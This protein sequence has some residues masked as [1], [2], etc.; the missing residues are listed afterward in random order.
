MFLFHLFFIYFLSTIGCL[1]ILH[2]W[3]HRRYYYL[4]FLIPGPSVLT[5]VRANIQVLM[6]TLETIPKLLDKMYNELRPLYP[7]IMKIRLGPKLMFLLD[8]DLVQKVFQTNLK[9]DHIIYSLMDPILNGPSIIQNSVIAKW[10]KNRKIISHT[11]FRMNSLRSY[12]KIFHEEAYILADKLGVQAGHGQLIEPKPMVGLATL[13]MVMRT[14]F[15]LDF[16]IQQNFHDKHPA[17]EALE[18][19]LE[20][21]GTRIFRPWLW[22]S[23]IFNLSRYKKRE[24]EAC[25]QS[26]AFAETIVAS[27]KAKIVQENDKQG[28]NN[29]PKDNVPS[30]SECESNVKHFQES[31]ID[32]DTC[33]DSQF[34]VIIR[35]QLN[36]NIPREDVIT[37]DELIS[38]ILILLLGGLDTTMTSNSIILIMLAL[39]PNIQ[40]EVYDEIQ[41]VVGTDP[42]HALTYDQLQE[43]HI[44]T[45]VIKETLRLFPPGPIVAREAEEEFQIN[46]YTIPKGASFGV[47]IYCGPHKDPHHW[48]NPTRF[49]PDRFLPSETEKRSPSAYLPFSTGPRSCIG[50]KYAMLQMKMTIST[51]L[52]RYRVLP[53]DVC[54]RIEDIRWSIQFTMQLLPGNDIRLEPRDLKM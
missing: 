46:G 19:G 6:G 42:N 16:K 40:Q 10:K 32:E 41:S 15:G 45:R 54:K 1:L 14:M 20:I 8:Y 51:I 28:E 4:C 47:F 22:M 5:L 44:L 25:K 18:A 9:K 49:D 43:L 34:D 30:G 37:H 23:T 38:E 11:S 24:V 2:V 52:R 3:Q 13:S 36:T 29:K 33:S 50:P 12:V 35:D 21:V 17:I 7:S 39:H 53:G 48:P 31:D 27:I 26:R